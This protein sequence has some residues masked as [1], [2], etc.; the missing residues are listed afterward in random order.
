V[1]TIKNG[2]RQSQAGRRPLVTILTVAFIAV[3]FFAGFVLGRSTA[4]KPAPAP[5]PKA[6]ATQTQDCKRPG[7]K[8]GALCASVTKEHGVTVT[9][10]YVTQQYDSA[11]SADYGRPVKKFYNYQQGTSVQLNYGTT[12]TLD[13]LCRAG[14]VA[15]T[16]PDHDY[17]YQY[18][19]FKREVCDYAQ[20]AKSDG[21]A[22]EC[23]RLMNDQSLLAT[24]A[25]TP[26]NIDDAC[27]VPVQPK[28]KSALVDT[29]SLQNDTE[30]YTDPSASPSKN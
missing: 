21:N 30:T 7:T 14:A 18:E 9:R 19:N 1:E 6:V 28:A 5:A 27:A 23:Y 11:Y 17:A 4:S 15:M 25:F 22:D 2:P 8:V 12:A 16:T 20:K 29:G 26:T 10:T 24:Q 3:L 13:D